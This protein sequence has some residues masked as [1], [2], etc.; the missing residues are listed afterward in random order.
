MCMIVERMMLEGTRCVYDRASRESGG[1]RKGASRLCRAGE[2]LCGAVQ[3]LRRG[4]V[5]GFHRGRFEQC[6]ESSV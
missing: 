1:V 6:W 4:C 2:R 3:Y 5:L